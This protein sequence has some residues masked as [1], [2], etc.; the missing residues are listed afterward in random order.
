MPKRIIRGRVW[1]WILG[2]VLLAA[3]VWALS[4]VLGSRDSD[5]KVEETTPQAG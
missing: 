5:V 4:M 3:V 1:P 2:V